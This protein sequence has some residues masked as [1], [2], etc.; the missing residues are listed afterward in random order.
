[1]KKSFSLQLMFFCSIDLL[2]TR[3]QRLSYALVGRYEKS[4]TAIDDS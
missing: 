4:K 3:D 1:M 2:L